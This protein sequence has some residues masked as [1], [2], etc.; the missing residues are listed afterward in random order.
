MRLSPDHLITF[1][2]VAQLGS[3]TDAA[4]HLNLSQSSVSAQ[5][6]LL[7]RQ[8]GQALYDRHSHGVTLTAA[9]LE[10]LP[11]AQ[12]VASHAARAAETVA[13]LGGVPA[14]TVRLGLSHALAG[15]AARLARSGLG[16]GAP[17]R[18]VRVIS[19]LSANLTEQV[20]AGQLD[21]AIVVDTGLTVPAP[22]ESR[23]IGE[24]TLIL[25]VHPGH[26]LAPLGYVAP[27]SLERETFL[28]PSPGSGVRRHA[29]RLLALAGVVPDSELELGS[30]FAV[31][32]ALLDAQGV[33][34]LTR[35][36]V[37]RAAQSGAL[38]AL[39]LEAPQVSVPLLLITPPAGTLS[40]ERRAFLSR[41]PAA[42]APDPPPEGAAR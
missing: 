32:E 2:V 6:K 3:V 4:R 38:R 31:H 7:Q 17:Q 11:H 20:R 36:F 39:G 22:L 15:A 8:T 19:G 28:W 21:A 29:Q 14:R 9:G 16:P 12:A 33:A 24:D 5:L 30:L 18:A 23:V 26:P 35:G 42:L 40:P 27:H 25:C 34:I 13:R 41:L 10:L 37:H 1:S